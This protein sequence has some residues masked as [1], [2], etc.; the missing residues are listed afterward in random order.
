MLKMIKTEGLDPYIM[1]PAA[2]LHDIGWKNV[3]TYLWHPKTDKEKKN[4]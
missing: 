1:V 2:M 4:S 3:P